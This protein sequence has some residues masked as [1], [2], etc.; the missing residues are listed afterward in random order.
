MRGQRAWPCPRCKTWSH[1]ASET[2][3]GALAEDREQTRVVFYCRGCKLAWVHVTEFLAP[4]QPVL[5]EVWAEHTGSEEEGHELPREDSDSEG[6]EIVLE[7]GGIDL[8]PTAIPAEPKQ[9]HFC[10]K[11]VSLAFPGFNCR[12]NCG[13]FFHVE[14]AAGRSGFLLCGDCPDTVGVVR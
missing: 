10:G 13:K 1:S 12:N 6:S 9:C 2:S 7:E 11:E 4:S 5:Q 3:L 14:C 8:E